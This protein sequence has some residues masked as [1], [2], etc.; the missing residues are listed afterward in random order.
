M[1]L[2][3]IL[4]FLFVSSA[5]ASDASFTLAEAQKNCA[6]LKSIKFTSIS[7]SPFSKG[8]LS[9][10][11]LAGEVFTS[12]NINAQNKYVMQP[13]NNSLN[14]TF[15]NISGYGHKSNDVITCFYEYTAFTGITVHS[16]MTTAHTNS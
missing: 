4:A 5:M 14:I 3:L 8:Y 12:W 15:S 11:N 16:V 13:K 1:S 2:S 6:T 10:I 9:G 7:P